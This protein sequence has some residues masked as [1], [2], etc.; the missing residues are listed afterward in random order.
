ML[1]DL[2]R[3]VSTDYTEGICKC[4]AHPTSYSKDVKENRSGGLDDDLEAD[5]EPYKPQGEMIGAL[6]DRA[7]TI[8]HQT[9]FVPNITRTVLEYEG[10][11]LM[12]LVP[13]DAAE[14]DRKIYPFPS[15]YGIRQSKVLLFKWT[16]SQGVLYDDNSN[17]I[18]KNRK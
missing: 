4:G 13:N 8:A 12:W 15:S 2:T 6:L 9:K 5:E 1:P 18:K 10:C 16:H 14:E 7:K 17:D 3:S 11:N